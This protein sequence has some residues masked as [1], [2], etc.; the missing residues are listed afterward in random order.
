MRKFF[1]FRS[2]PFQY[3]CAFRFGFS[4][5]P[6]SKRPDR[7]PLF[8]LSRP[9]P[10]VSHLRRPGAARAQP[11]EGVNKLKALVL[12]LIK[13]KSLKQDTEWVG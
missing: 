12:K 1:L 2:V 11:C 9:R 7:R 10:N 3:F 13:I 4:Q 8:F 5:K 6:N